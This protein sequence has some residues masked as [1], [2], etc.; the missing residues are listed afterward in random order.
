MKKRVMKKQRE[1]K[2]GTKKK[3][4]KKKFMGVIAYTNKKES[5]VLQVYQGLK[6]RV[7]PTKVTCHL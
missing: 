5:L 1:V 6:C 4:E 7:K 2:K 3:G